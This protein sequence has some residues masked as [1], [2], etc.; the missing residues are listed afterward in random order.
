MPLLATIYGGDS[1]VRD[2]NP[3]TLRNTTATETKPRRR[4]RA[5]KEV[6]GRII[7]S[8]DDTVGAAGS[9]C[10]TAMDDRPQ[11]LTDS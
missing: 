5:E 3:V 4:E 7:Y 2:Q 9:P 8:K 6:E 10:R 1:R 11:A